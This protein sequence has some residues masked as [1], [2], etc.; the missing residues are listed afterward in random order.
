MITSGAQITQART[1]L[2][3]SKADLARAAGLD[4]KAVAWWERKVAIT[5]VTQSPG[6]EKIADALQ[7][8][9]I[10]FPEPLMIELSREP[11][12]GDA[13]LVRLGVLRPK[14]RRR[15][16]KLCRRLDLA[17]AVEPAQRL[18]SPDWRVVHG[19]ECG[20]RTRKGLP[21]K[22]PAYRNGRCRSHGGLCT[23]ARAAE[24]RARIA[25]AQRRRWAAAR[26]S[27][28]SMHAQQRA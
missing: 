6:V 18:Q 21:C 24:G 14:P 13:M 19:V 26:R 7:R 3:W 10:H 27:E 12:S 5:G 20:A 9:G 16:P 22:R 15:K 4:R 1:S 2:G 23:G 25:E 8:A 11:E 17:L 28:H